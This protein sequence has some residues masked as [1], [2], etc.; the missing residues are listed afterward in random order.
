MDG[1]FAGTLDKA[2][3]TVALRHQSDSSNDKLMNVVS[4]DNG[5][6]SFLV[7]YGGA[8][9]GSY[10]LEVTSEANGRYFSNIVI[11][12]GSSVTSISPT[13]GSLLGG[14]LITITGENFSDDP[15]D[16]PVQIDGKDCA[17]ESSSSTE[18]KCR[19]PAPSSSSDSTHSVLVFLK[20]TEEAVCSGTCDFT[21]TSSKTP[22]L[23]SQTISFDYPNQLYKIKLDGSNFDGTTSTVSLSIDG[24]AQSI[25]SVSSTQVVATLTGLTGIQS[26]DIKFYLENGLPSGSALSGGF[27]FE[28]RLV[29]VSPNVGSSS[30]SVLTLNVQGVGSGAEIAVYAGST[31][32]CESIE[33]PAYSEVTCKTKAGTVA[34][35]TELSIKIGSTTFQCSNGVTTH[36]EYQTGQT[37]SIS[38]KSVS[39]NVLTLSGSDF[40]QSG[41]DSAVVSLNGVEA[42]SVT[43]TPGSHSL[44]ATFDHGIPASPAAMTPVVGFKSNSFSSDNLIHY[45]AVS[46]TVSNTLSITGSNSIDCSYNGGCAY[47]LTAN[48]LASALKGGSAKIT[49]CGEACEF[50]SASSSGTTAVCTTPALSTIYSVDNY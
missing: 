32:L 38:T 10:N 25:D 27:Y 42:T 24:V 46:A 28:P 49:L 16:N 13:S 33:I 20:A 31:E 23:S 40:Y 2:D 14:T 37:P 12:V 4:V 48:G 19:T 1:A 22:A 41:F 34:A 36:C 50:D 45:A 21:Y 44:D 6:K 3:L 11:T 17:I 7:K 18:I 29:S 26:T 47:S 30:G 8:K 15:L 39:G 5:A 9:S 35:E 43:V